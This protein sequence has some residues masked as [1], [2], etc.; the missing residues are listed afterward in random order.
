VRTV[1]SIRRREQSATERPFFETAAAPA[2]ATRLLLV[3]PHFPPGQGA[4][5]LRW[6]KLTTHAAARGYAVDVITIDPPTLAEPDFSRLGTLPAGVRVF[7]VPL[8]QLAI[9]RW[10]NRA[11][12]MW[13]PVARFRRS[14]P[15]AEDN[16]PAPIY[17]RK[18]ALQA[19]FAWRDY[20]IHHDWAERATEL[21]LTLARR[22]PYGCV[23]T[24]GPPHM[25]HE[26]GRRVSVA[27]GLPLVLDLR[28]PWSLVERL[29]WHISSPVWWTFARKYEPRAVAQAKLIV[30]T[31]EPA[32]AAMRALYPTRV[33]RIIAVPNGFD[34]EV[35]PPTVDRPRRFVVA[36]AGTIYLD[37]N[38]T[39]LFRAVAQVVHELE[40]TPDQF[41]LEFMGSVA[42]VGERRTR[43]LARAAGIEPF[44]RLHPTQPRDQA[45]RFLAG[46]S[47]LVSLHQDSALA[48]PGKLFEYMLFDAWVLVLTEAGTA[49]AQILEGTSADVVPDGDPGQIAHVLKERYVQFTKGVRPK[50]IVG[51]DR[52]SRR[53]QA[54]RL[55]DALEALP[56]ARDP[57][58]SRVES[59]SAN[60]FR[61][62]GNDRR[63]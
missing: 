15:A 29:P 19:Y 21:A 31:S 12:Q 56:G 30:T 50:R 45:L 14:R 2:T 11:W 41:G 38:P 35:L 6:E 36:F 22:D 8:H 33:T 28:D 59:T 58:P 55:F 3:S 9:D 52:L 62:A 5:A 49:T 4:G 51:D 23:V 44:L 24:C 57:S 61:F 10:V 17:S 39:G 54:G 60:G 18:A 25:V 47:V 40:L 27:T 42:T 43:D 7:G 1:P 16:E 26:A 46:A 37:R 63:A 13:R 20:A 32:A 34:D 48:I 53:V